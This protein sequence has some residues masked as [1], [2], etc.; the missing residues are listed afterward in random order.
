[1]C[2]E[3]TYKQIAHTTQ[4]GTGTGQ[5]ISIGSFTTEEAPIPYGA[6]FVQASINK[7][8]G[9]INI[10]KYYALHD[11]GTPINPELA[12]GQ[13]Y[14][15]VLKTIGHSLYEELKFNKQGKCINP[16]FLDYKVPMINEVPD[17]FQAKLIYVEDTLGPFGAK[18]IGEVVANG[19]APAIASA[20][21]NAT[22]IWLR[23]WPFASE[24]IY[25]ALNSE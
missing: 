7:Q 6:H 15:G 2:V 20:I 22:G 11:C 4:S 10:D 18:S 13:I 5:L 12:K 17:D 23:S 14:G 25:K 1:M 24:K 9:H 8:T 16:N 19:A 3:I 21:H